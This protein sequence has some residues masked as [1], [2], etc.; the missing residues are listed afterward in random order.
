MTLAANPVTQHCAS[1]FLFDLPTQSLCYAEF[2]SR[3]PNSSCPSPLSLPLHVNILIFFFPSQNK[4]AALTSKSQTILCVGK[5][6][7]KDVVL[8]GVPVSTGTDLLVVVT[9]GIYKPGNDVKGSI[10]S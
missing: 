8:G 9:A 7:L 5:G 4:A 1:N 6:L 3:L 10:K 2:P